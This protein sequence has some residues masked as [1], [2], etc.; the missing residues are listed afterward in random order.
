MKPT[1][2]GVVLRMQRFDPEARRLMQVAQLEADRAGAAHV[3]MEHLAVAILTTPEAARVARRV[4]TDREPHL[5]ALRMRCAI[6]PPSAGGGAVLDE[7]LLRAIAELE[8]RTGERVIGVQ[9]LALMLSEHLLFPR[10]VA[11]GLPA[12]P[13][14]VARRRAADGAA[15]RWNGARLRRLLGTSIEPARRAEHLLR[16]FARL[17]RD[18]HIPDLSAEVHGSRLTVG[19]QD[20]PGRVRAFMAPGNDILILEAHAPEH[21]ALRRFGLD[22]E[23]L[24][25]HDLAEGD[26]LEDALCRAIVDALYPE[27][28]GETDTL[29][30]RPPA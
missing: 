28:R 20:H 5:T 19:R 29:H 16:Y 12:P 25:F 1:L 21:V 9:D 13:E 24:A 17:L 22:A 14:L 10:S 2:P 26:E 3:V 15:I 8:R 30:V 11:E 7:T 27:V 18:Q 6:L 23:T 4:G